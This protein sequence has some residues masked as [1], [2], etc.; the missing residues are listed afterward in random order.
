M[1]GKKVGTQW[2]EFLGIVWPQLLSAN[3]S[4]LATGSTS[5]SFFLFCLQGKGHSNYSTTLDLVCDVKA[6]VGNPGPENNYTDIMRGSCRYYFVWRSLYACPK[7]R[8]VDVT[9]IYSDCVN[10]TRNIT[11]VRSLPCFGFGDD[12]DI[13]APKT[14]EC[15]VPTETV[16]VV[17]VNT[18]V[19][20]LVKESSKVNK[21]LIG[22]GVVVIV[23]LLAVAG[24]F[25]YKHRTMKY[26]YYTLMARNKPMSRLEKEEDENSFFGD[27]EPDPFD[28]TTAPVR[29]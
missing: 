27:Q 1:L 24:L 18:T 17:V 29:T 13:T 19:S 16:T 7:C 15:V 6:G 23:A 4:R 26:R 11:Y 8:K 3:K 25:V 10:G 14:E 28:S 21:I 20:Y 12:G 22:V 2:P 9:A 5:V